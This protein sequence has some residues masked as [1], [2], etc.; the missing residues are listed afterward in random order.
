MI[1]ADENL[2]HFFIKALAEKGYEIKSVAT[3]QRGASDEAVIELT[4]AESAILITED[5]DFGELVFAH[6][7]AKVTVIFLR[8][9]LEELPIM[10]RNLFK[11]V[12]DFSSQEGRFFIV[13]TSTRIRIRSI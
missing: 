6:Q 5:K 12:E 13:V 4:Q 11:V 8:Y 7:I 2:H 9:R 10:L 3:L 1:V